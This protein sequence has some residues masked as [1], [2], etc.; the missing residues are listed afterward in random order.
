MRLGFIGEE[1]KHAR[2]MLTENLSG[3]SAWL[4]KMEP[5]LE[6]RQEEAAPEPSP[7]SQQEETMLK[8]VL[9]N[10]QDEAVTEAAQE[11]QQEDTEEIGGR[12]MESPE[13]SEEDNAPILQENE[14]TM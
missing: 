6:N 1:Y 8:P 12:D 10:Q 4:R 3:N 11:N 13:S 14:M 7:E 2:K 5:A 9:E